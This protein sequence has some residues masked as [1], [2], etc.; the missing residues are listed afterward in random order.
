MR[1][2]AL[3]LSTS[4]Q[5]VPA[6]FAKTDELVEARE[7]SATV[8]LASTPPINAAKQTRSTLRST[9]SSRSHR[10]QR[11]PVEI[12]HLKTAYKKNWGRMP[13]VLDRIKQARERGLDITA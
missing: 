4:L 7:S 5:Y 2:G 6:R 1:D 3:G 10:K 12:W 11:F 8:R 9:K 13:Y